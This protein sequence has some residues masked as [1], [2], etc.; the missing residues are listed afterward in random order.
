MPK[1]VEASRFMLST[2]TIDLELTKYA[3][4]NNNSLEGKLEKKEAFG[5]KT[6][7]CSLQPQLLEKFAKNK[8]L[9]N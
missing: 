8:F 2:S 5:N 9:R 1:F 7:K 3:P 6:F 4:E